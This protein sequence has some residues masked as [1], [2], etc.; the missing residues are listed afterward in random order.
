MSGEEWER[1]KSIFEAALQ[2]PEDAREAFLLSKCGDEPALHETLKEL[3][4]N[5]WDD[6]VRYTPSSQQ[7]M[8]SE[9]TLVAGRFRITR[10]IN[11]GSMGEVYGK[12]RKKTR[13]TC[14]PQR[15]NIEWNNG[16]A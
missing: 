1:I 5:H 11:S 15:G 16:T 13:K 8:F 2:V 6:S 3:I 4:K 9:S 7:R 10:F 14:L 12:G